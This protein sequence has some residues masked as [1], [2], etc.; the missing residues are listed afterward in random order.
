M[1]KVLLGLSILASL[2]FSA[3]DICYGLYKVENYQK[4][5]DCY[6]KQLK[7]SN[8]FDNNFLAGASLSNQGRYKE[9]LLYLQKAEQLGS[10]ER[11]LGL[12]YSFLSVVYSSLGNDE[13][14]LAYTMK[15]LNNSLKRNHKKDISSAYNNLGGYYHSMKDYNKALEYYNKSLEFKEEKDNGLAYNNMALI[16]GELENY[17]KSN[18]FYNKSINARLNRGD[19][20]GLCNSKTNFGT[21]LYKQERYQ[22][23]DK[24]LKEANPICHN[25]GDISIEANS[26][27]VLGLSSLKQQDLQLAKSYY[28]QAKPLANKSGESTILS[29]LADL[30]KRISS[31]NQ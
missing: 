1:K 29:N 18:E 31:Y 17:D 19:Y 24:V 16:Y 10:S 2:S 9:A 12:T 13:L 30:E 5:G 8:S 28:N 6:I 25:T 26:F 4:S 14:D 21:S 11:D 27:I 15:F 7:I 23:A 20:L 22:E 3:E